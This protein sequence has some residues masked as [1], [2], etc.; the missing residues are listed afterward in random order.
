MAFEQVIA[1]TASII[2]SGL[3]GI[4]SGY[5]MKK[6][7]IIS[8]KVFESSDEKVSKK[9]F[10]PSLVFTVFAETPAIYGLLISI[11]ILL[12]ITSVQEINMAYAMLLSAIAVGVP[13]FSAAYGIGLVSAAAMA[14]VAEK[15]KLFGKSLVF[16]IF[17]ETI[18]IYGLLMA[19]LLL[20]GSGVIGSG[21]I[22]TN[23]QLGP[24]IL[25]TVIIAVIGGVMAYFLGQLGVHAIKALLNDEKVFVYSLVIVA[26][27]ES[28][29]IYGLLVSIM[30]LSG[31]K[32]L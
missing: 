16:V 4:A 25:A 8:E 14:A 3:T 29:A 13:S 32:I 5:Q 23:E 12:N 15:P 21:T 2:S 11:L 6:L 19:L 30:I 17:P 27:P 9:F 26:L 31:A 1:I 22:I 18:A 20:M 7:G 10:T 28:I 24:A